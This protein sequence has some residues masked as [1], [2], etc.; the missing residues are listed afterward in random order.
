MA[1]FR[2]DS[3][4]KQTNEIQLVLYD[5]GVYRQLDESVRINYSH[6]WRAILEVNEKD[7]IKYGELLGAGK[8]AQLMACMVSNKTWDTL[9]G[10]KG[11][12]SKEVIQA[13]AIQYMKEITQVLSSLPR[14][15]LLIFKT[16]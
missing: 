9:I 7:I 8:L 3:N 6:F 4:G 2:T 15:I 12:D 11:E 16:K 1:R 14:Q 10:K 5:H 13:S